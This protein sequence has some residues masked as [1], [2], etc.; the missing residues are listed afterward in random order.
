MKKFIIYFY[1]QTSKDTVC[2]SELKTGFQFILK[3]ISDVFG[4]VRPTCSRNFEISDKNWNKMGKICVRIYITMM[5]TLEGVAGFE[6]QKR[7]F[8]LVMTPGS[9][10]SFRIS[11]SEYFKIM[12]IYKSL[13]F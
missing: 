9:K 1:E 7:C 2:Q 13:V 4:P 6:V 3:K 11:I 10:F 12:Q 8:L 5:I